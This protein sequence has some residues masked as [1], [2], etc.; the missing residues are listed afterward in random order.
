MEN[1]QVLQEVITSLTQA[2][3]DLAHS[4]ALIAENAVPV[5]VP[6]KMPANA[7]LAAPPGVMAAIAAGAPVSVP[8]AGLPL[9]KALSDHAAPVARS[10]QRIG[11]AVPVFAPLL[12]T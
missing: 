8:P 9:A 6:V 3:S 7:A 5:A 11:Q 10:A 2:G 1:S 4:A 12:R